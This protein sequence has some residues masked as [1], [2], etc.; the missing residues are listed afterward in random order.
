MCLC[1]KKR[2]KEIKMC[3]YNKTEDKKCVFAEIF[4]CLKMCLYNKKE[5]KK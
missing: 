3:L 4:I 2:R 1:N 5:E